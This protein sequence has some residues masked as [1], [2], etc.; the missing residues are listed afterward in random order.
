MMETIRVM[1]MMSVQELHEHYMAVRARINDPKRAFVE[2]RTPTAVM[3]VPDSETILR[4]FEPNFASP[5]EE[6]IYRTARKHRVSVADMRS[7]SRRQAVVLARN[8]AAYEIRNQ[9]GLSFPQIAALFGRDHS[10]I[11]HGIH[12]HAALLAKK[13]AE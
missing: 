9:R 7:A 1:K 11:F 6:I 10:T 4:M 12:R 8:E 3:V 13:S 5:S 2:K